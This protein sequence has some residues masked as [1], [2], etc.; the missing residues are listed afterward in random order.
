MTP[1]E[2]ASAFGSAAIRAGSLEPVL[3]DFAEHRMRASLKENFIAG[4]RP[5]AWIPSHDHPGHRATL[6][7][8]GALVDSTT[9]FVENGTDVVLAAGGGGQPEAKAPTLQYGAR[10]T[11]KRRM[12][13]SLFG[14]SRSHEDAGQFVTKRSRKD[15]TRH[16]IVIEARPYLLFQDEDLTYLDHE[17]TDF[18]FGKEHVA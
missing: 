3:A 12:A 9:A 10:F 5:V 8:T 7:D 14:L 15:I 18:I 13:N 6:V 11:A 2:F 4:G 16:E 1:E 17:I